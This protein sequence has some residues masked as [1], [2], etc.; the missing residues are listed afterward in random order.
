MGRFKDLTGNKFNEWTV[1]SR[2][3]NKYTFAS[4]NCI[5]SCGNKSIV[6]GSSLTRGKSKSCL[7]CGH[8]K[9]GKEVRASIITAAFKYFITYNEKNR[10]K[11]KG[12]GLQINQTEY[13][14]IAKND[15]FYCGEPPRLFSPY[16]SKDEVIHVNGLDRVNS[17][18]PY[19]KDNCVACCF[20]CNQAKNDLSQEEF[21]EKVKRIYEKNNLSGRQ[22]G[23]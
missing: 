20:K 9:R 16:K 2:A 23:N 7:K 1:M 4:W 12:I 18:G 10:R 13:Y 17:S 11:G 3:E 14:E 8:K 15:C 6:T 19:S 22:D 5:C 21:F